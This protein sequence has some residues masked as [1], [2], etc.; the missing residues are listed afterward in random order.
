MYIMY[1]KL[2]MF[3][4][5]LLP[6]FDDSLQKRWNYADHGKCF[7]YLNKMITFQNSLH[8]LENFEET[9]LFLL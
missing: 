1:S 3:K 7:A 2:V 5:I 4:I 8:S 6:N 9:H